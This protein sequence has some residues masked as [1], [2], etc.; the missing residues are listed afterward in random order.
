MSP[1]IFTWIA[2]GLLLV[3]VLAVFLPTLAQGWA[4]LDDAI[5][6][7]RNPH[8]RGFSAENLR[9][10]WTSRLTGHYIPLS[11]MTL[12]ADYDLSAMD[13]R[14]FHRTNVLLHALNA[15]LFFALARTLIRSKRETPAIANGSAAATTLGAFAA[16]AFFAVH[17]LRVESVA[18]LTERRDLL[19]G[20]FCLLSVLSYVRSA[21]S[22][23]SERRWAQVLSLAAYL[24]ALLSKGLAVV[25]PVA[26]L[27][28]DAGPLDRLQGG[29]KRWLSRAN[30]WVL[31][32]KAPFLA[33]AALFSV[34]T[35]W[36]AAPV[37][38]DRSHAGLEH[39]FL[40]AGF[41]LSFYLEK[42]LLPV[43]LPFQV[44]ATVL[45][46][47]GSAPVVALRGAAFLAVCIGA[48]VIWRRRPEVALGLAVFSAFVLPV[49]GL[50]QAGPQL[51]AH[52]YTYLAGLPIAL[53]LGGAVFAVT[54]RSNALG[55]RLLASVVLLLVLSLTFTARAQVALWQD[56]VT[57]CTAAVAAA[58]LA[59]A[60]VAA[61]SRAYLARNEPGKALEVLRAGRVRQPGALV[62]TYLEALVLA[63]TD[64]D[65]VRDGAAALP[66][67]QQAAR[68]TSF[69]DPAGLLALA[70]AV[71]EQ[72]D[73]DGARRLLRSAIALARSGRKP[74][75]LPFLE[76]IESR[77]IA[78]GQIRMKAV[79]WQVEFL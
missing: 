72:G 5:N 45:L 21:R 60:P 54:A 12:A 36:A 65:D 73:L 64:S 66:L 50:F 3:L 44:P 51:A 7:E 27:A 20:L 19:C 71:A 34:V 35:F 69:Q 4:P 77:F 13:P 55:R 16:A 59:S 74:E 32:E 1:R 15:L 42:T 68:A 76:D 17:P 31:L 11:W 22:T 57:F 40:S 25:L 29:P 9:W 2:A 33:L 58:P 18:W 47:V 6:F 24:A 8:F 56:A 39:R 52:R 70:A 30:R 14:G 53:L 43:R 61:L 28:L 49:S 78:S 48:L 23:G 10:M 46:S 67:A 38:V 75:L 63:G 41:A 62:L 79:D 37:L 26:L